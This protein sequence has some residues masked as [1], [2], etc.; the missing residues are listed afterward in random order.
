LAIHYDLGTRRFRGA[1]G[2]FASAASGM[3]SSVA[4]VEYHEAISYLAVLT[5]K[6]PTIAEKILH[7]SPFPPEGYITRPLTPEPQPQDIYETQAIDIY[8]L[9]DMLDVDTDEADQYEIENG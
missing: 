5:Q 6:P 2:R 3:R 4:R 9:Y 8:D 1:D 7:T